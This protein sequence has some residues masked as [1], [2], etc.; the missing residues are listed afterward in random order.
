MAERLRLLMR[1]PLEKYQDYK[2]AV[3]DLHLP[4]VGCVHYDGAKLAGHIEYATYINEGG[5]LKIMM[6]TAAPKPPAK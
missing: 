6:L 1:R 2:V 5:N 3:R 4:T